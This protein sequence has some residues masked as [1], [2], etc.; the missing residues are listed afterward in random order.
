MNLAND[1]DCYEETEIQLSN[2]PERI[3]FKESKILNQGKSIPKIQFFVPNYLN[4][5]V[6]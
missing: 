1:D 5:I 4:Y 2:E 6:R 3:E